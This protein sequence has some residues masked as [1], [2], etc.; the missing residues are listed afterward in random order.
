MLCIYYFTFLS[1]ISLYIVHDG[2]SKR[3][4]IMVHLFQLAYAA[5]WHLLERPF[6][7]SYHLT[8][9]CRD[10]INKERCMCMSTLKLL[11]THLQATLLGI[12]E[13][14]LNTTN[15]LPLRR[16]NCRKN[17][18]RKMFFECHIFSFSSASS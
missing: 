4:V 16:L 13:A 11:S 12:S 17:K 9:K 3:I 6:P 1:S 18:L 14:T 10:C 5:I 2:R 8:H 7:S 15:F